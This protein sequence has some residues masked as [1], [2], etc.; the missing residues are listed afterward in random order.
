MAVN[1]TMGLLGV[2]SL[3]LVSIQGVPTC[4]A[5]AKSVRVGHVLMAGC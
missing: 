3:I 4:H 1:I 5:D 2:A